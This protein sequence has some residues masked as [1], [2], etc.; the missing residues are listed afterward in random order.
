MSGL[1]AN[2]VAFAIRGHQ[3]PPTLPNNIYPTRRLSLHKDQ[4]A[5]RARTCVLDLGPAACWLWRERA[6]KSAAAQLAAGAV[7]NDRQ[8]ERALLSISAKGENEKN[9][10]W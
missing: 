6:K 9:Q 7:I 3:L 2:S 8:A 4:R 5:F 1:E 10:C